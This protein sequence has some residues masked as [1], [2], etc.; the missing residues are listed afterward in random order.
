MNTQLFFT[1]KNTV[2]KN[3]HESWHNLLPSSLFIMQKVAMIEILKVLGYSVLKEKNQL[4]FWVM[5][6]ILCKIFPNF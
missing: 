4:N 6:K 3:T 5:Q 1:L 2:L